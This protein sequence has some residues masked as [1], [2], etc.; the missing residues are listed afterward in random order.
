MEVGAGLGYEYPLELDRAC[1]CLRAENAGYEI[2][3]GL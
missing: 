3:Y 1:H 2:S